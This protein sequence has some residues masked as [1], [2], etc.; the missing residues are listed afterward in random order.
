MVRAVYEAG[1]NG[2]TTVQTALGEK[3]GITVEHGLRFDR[4]F[5][6]TIMTDARAGICELS[7][8]RVLIHE[9]KISNMKDLLPLLE[10]VVRS[11]A[12]LLIVAGEVEGEALATLVVNNVGKGTIRCAAVKA[13]GYG[14]RRG[15]MLQDIAVLTGVTF[16][17]LTLGLR[18]SPFV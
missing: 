1:K 10:Q 15:A 5:L 8:C 16:Y 13:P 3:S 17:R 7:N 6:Q 4:G 11:S 14:D 12:P 9:H 2:F 18:S